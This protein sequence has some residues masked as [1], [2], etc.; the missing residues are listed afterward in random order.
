M[1]VPAVWIFDPQRR[2]V[3]LCSPD[4]STDEKIAGMV[5]LSGTDITLD[6]IEVFSAL[7]ED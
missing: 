2:S 7:D 4:G 3:T 6:L 1:G 5:Q